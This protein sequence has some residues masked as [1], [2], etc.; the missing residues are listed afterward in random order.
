MSNKSSHVSKVRKRTLYRNLVLG[1]ILTALWLSFFYLKMEARLLKEL[2]DSI[3]CSH[4][5]DR[6]INDYRSLYKK[7]IYTEE[8]VAKG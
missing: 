3:I 8:K 1:N 5:I 6:Y 7:S 4:L 2:S